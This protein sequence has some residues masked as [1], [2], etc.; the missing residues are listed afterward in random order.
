VFGAGV[1]AFGKAYGVLAHSDSGVGVYAESLDSPDGLGLGPAIRG[2][3]DSGPGVVGDGDTVGVDGRGSTGVRGRSY[4]GLS[5]LPGAGVAGFSLTPIEGGDAP[6]TG[7]GVYGSSGSGAGVYGD[8]PDQGVGVFGSSSSGEGIH[9]QGGPAGRGGVFEI[10]AAH[11]GNRA[12]T[13]AAQLRM[14]P[15]EGTHPKKGEAGDFFV[16]AKNRLWYCSGG[17]NWTQLA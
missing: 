11:R 13:G 5:D 10:P 4:A 15:S 17:P 14:I 12:F 6:G 2:V 1:E 8:A 3:C 9:G 16:D 7:V